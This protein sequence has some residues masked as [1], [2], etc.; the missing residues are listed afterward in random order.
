MYDLAITNGSV[1]FD[2]KYH[3]TNVYIK[4][5]VIV[6]ISPLLLKSSE[7]YDCKGDLVLPG[8]IDPHTHF[9][10]HLGR[11]SSRDDFLYGT[12]AAAYGGVTSIIDFIDPVDNAKSLEESFI[13]RCRQ[14]KRS[15]VDFKLHA[16]LKNPKDNIDE[17][18]DKMID[19]GLDTVKIFTTYSDS[20]RRTY[21]K[22]I[23]ELLRL[24]KEKDYMVTAHIENDDM[25]SQN[26]K[27]KYQELPES[28]PTISETSEAL[29]MAK[30]AKETN[31]NLYMVH[32]SSGETLKRLKD[33]YSDILNKNFIIESCPHYF[34]FDKEIIKTKEGYLYTMAPPLR[35]KGEVKLLTMLIDD[36]YTIG[37]DHCSFNK[38][39]KKEEYLKD[40]PL[41]IGGIEHSFNV[42]YQIF[43]D[44]IIDKMTKNV[45]IAHRLFPQKGI[46]AEQ[47]DADLFIYHL[48]NTKI[49]KNH[50]FTD[51]S[52][53]KNFPV[54]GEIISTISRGKFIVK[55]GIFI[56]R[57]GQLLNKGGAS[58]ACN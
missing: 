2:Q 9:Q 38:K 48:E 42:M 28:R 21:D 5:G 40:M 11:I 37:T 45:A 49:T 32:L 31:G 19:L 3:R 36:V 26:Y 56:N 33:Q 1:Y 23:I 43:G 14:A 53:Y 8:I 55:R 46:I 58:D 51:Y 35:S 15:V 12:K 17:I 29:K 27:M 50:G 24:S 54:K 57:K 52:V 44:K 34:V 41:G 18:T 16:C 47:S 22:E 7:V 4:D 20:L 6:N 39:D 30:Y 13:K 10:L 25:I